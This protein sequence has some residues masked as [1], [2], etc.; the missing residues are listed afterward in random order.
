[1]QSLRPALGGN[2][3]WNGKAHELRVIMNGWKG[4][5]S[6]R[7][8]MKS[9]LNMN[10]RTRTYLQI[11]PS[12]CIHPSFPP[13]P[14]PVPTHLSPWNSMSLLPCRFSTSFLRRRSTIILSPTVASAQAPLLFLSRLTLTPL[15]PA[16]LPRGSPPRY[17]W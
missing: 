7:Y 8:I 3:W 10:P 13:T 9:Q 14:T 4:I 6:V 2:A 5:N 17:F 15:R 12:S 11:R 16:A 1:V